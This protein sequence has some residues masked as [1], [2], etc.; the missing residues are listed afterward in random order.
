MKSSPRVAIFGCTGFIG[1]G[2]PPA[3]AAHGLA[4]TGISRS[5]HPILSGVDRWAT[6]DTINLANHHAVINLAGESVACR[7]TP[8]RFARIR[9]SRIDFTRRL[10]DAIRALPPAE[11]PKVLVNAS[12]VGIYGNRDEQQLNESAAAG[13]GMLADLCRDWEATAREAT[14]LGVRVVLP[15]IGIVLGR[16]GGALAKLLPLFSAGLGG[17]LGHGRQWMPWIHL[18]DLRAA[19][20]HAVV[21]DSID[22]PINASSPQPV[23]NA[24]FSHC[25]GQAVHRP[26]ILPVPAIALKLALGGFGCT[27]LDS[28]RVHPAALE[29]NGFAFQ[30]PNLQNALNHILTTR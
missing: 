19:I 4:C 13:D 23:R 9:S 3:L 8:T 29:T 18:D 25:L 21:T 22:G 5:H 14:A 12:A 6:P 2:L 30:F 10:V 27:L 20:V 24:D 7:W 15:R 11:R 26:A 16:H 1:R 17:R 28:Q